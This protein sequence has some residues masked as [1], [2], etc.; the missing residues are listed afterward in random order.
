MLKK[1]SSFLEEK[2]SHRMEE[3]KTS[4][5]V[6]DM[7]DQSFFED[8]HDAID[9]QRIESGQSPDA[10]NPY[11]PKPHEQKPTRK[12]SQANLFPQEQPGEDEE[13]SED[14]PF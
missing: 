9:W 8:L 12:D 3:K 5:W 7:Q 10:P 11:A 2:N 4:V 14:L 1:D 13:P 6:I